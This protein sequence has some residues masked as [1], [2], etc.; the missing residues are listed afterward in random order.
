MAEIAKYG[1]PSLSTP[2]PARENHLSGGI[3]GENIA[4]G[5]ACR[6]GTDGKI[7][8][9][10]GA[11]NNASAVV[12]G[13]AAT[14]AQAGDAVTLFWF[15][16]FGYGNGMTPGTFLYLSGTVLGG[17]ADAPSTGGINP[18]ARVLPDG[19]RIWTKKS[20]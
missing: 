8:R 12:D 1:I 15:V 17:L 9:S 16:N 18:V 11:A 5:D 2:L 19:Q 3:C 10:N 13:F 7:Y 14:K 4:A 20:Y 6:I